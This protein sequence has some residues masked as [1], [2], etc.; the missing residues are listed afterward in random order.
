[1]ITT[2]GKHLRRS[3]SIWQMMQHA[4]EKLHPMTFYSTENC[5]L[6]CLHKNK[7]WVMDRVPGTVMCFT[8]SRC[9]Q[10][11]C[12]ENVQSG[13]CLLVEYVRCLG[14]ITPTEWCW[15]IWNKENLACS[16]GVKMTLEVVGQYRNSCLFV[17]FYCLHYLLS[18][19]WALN[20]CWAITHRGWTFWRKRMW[21]SSMPFH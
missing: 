7:E 14:M 5:R 11:P 12:R 13:L 3:G 10:P 2:L 17:F 18:E 9:P 6:R 16:R 20:L 4:L 8:V 21:Y 1:M 15:V 19:T